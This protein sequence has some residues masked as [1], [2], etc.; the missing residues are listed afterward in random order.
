MHGISN[1]ATS[2]GDVDG[3]GAAWLEHEGVDGWTHARVIGEVEG[4]G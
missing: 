3:K 1:L 2:E 4:K